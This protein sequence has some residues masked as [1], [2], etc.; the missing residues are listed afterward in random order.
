MEKQEIQRKALL[1]GAAIK[2]EL[3]S[4]INTYIINKYV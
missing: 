1:D 2:N 3:L 4:G